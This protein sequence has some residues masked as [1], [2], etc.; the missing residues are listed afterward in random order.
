M[1]EHAPERI[2]STIDIPKTVAG[3]LAAVSAAVIGSFLGVA[4][5]LAGA[6]IASVVGSVGTEIYHRWIDRGR[7]KI[8]STFVT[9]P[10][11]VGT[12]PVA[13]SHTAA[14][15]AEPPGVVR[16]SA[17]VPSPT[18]PRAMRWGRVVAVAAALFVLAVALLTVFELVAHRSI[19]DT[20]GHQSGRSTTIGS[21][22]T[23]HERRSDRAPAESPS[24]EPS[25]SSSPSETPSTTEPTPSQEPTNQAPFTGGPTTEPPTQ[26][27]QPTGGP[28]DQSGTGQGGTD[29][30]GTGQDGAGQGG[31]GQDGA[32]QG[33]TGQDGAAGQGGTGF[34]GGADQGTPTT[35]D[36]E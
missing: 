17:T 10:A 14:S 24:P 33:G 9:A 16:A 30:G 28:T 27:T 4:G 13:A 15:Q 35:Q 18:P 6:A 20:V 25:D 26:G 5:T 32:G 21:V 3:V 34:R 7:D 1:T 8:K 22:L 31:T 12:P 11:A 2:W 19:A 36:S 23:G 29:Q